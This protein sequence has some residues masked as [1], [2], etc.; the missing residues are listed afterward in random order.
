VR[1][2]VP[3][4][5]GITHPIDAFLARKMAEKGII[6]NPEADKRTLI[7]RLSLDLIGLP[8]KPEKVDAFVN[9]KDPKAYEKLVDRLMASPHYGERMALPWLDAARYADSNGFQ[10]DGDTFQWVW[11]DWVV[12][13]INDNMP[14]DRFTIEQLAGDLLPK[15]TPEQKVRLSK[16]A[17]EDVT[18]SSLAGDAIVDKMTKAPGNQAAIGGLKVTTDSGWF[19]ARPSG[20][21]NVYKIY[22][23]SFKNEEHLQRIFKEAEEI[24]SETLK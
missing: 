4:I 8:P 13:A 6:P 17:P 20:T 16:L 11:R 19:A 1:P 10:Q 24:V 9:D 23:E 18:A 12:K 3:K 5:G 14:F 7:R 15:A 22:A 2:P 21:E